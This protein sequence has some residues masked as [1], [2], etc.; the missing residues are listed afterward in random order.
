VWKEAVVAREGTEQNHK[1]QDNNARADTRIG[2]LQDIN[3]KRHFLGE[4]AKQEK[5]RTKHMNKNKQ[6]KNNIC[7]Y[8]SL[9]IRYTLHNDLQPT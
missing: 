9:S 6:A 3:Q 8:I 2:N 5:L 4:L 1:P 7:T